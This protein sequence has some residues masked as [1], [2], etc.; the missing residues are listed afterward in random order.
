MPSNEQK[1]IQ[2]FSDALDLDKSIIEDKLEYNTIP[3][4]DSI[5]HMTLIAAIDDSFDIML[6]T[7]DIIDMS[8]FAKAKKIISKHGIEF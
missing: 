8:T 1:L 7:D 6:E 2:I 5:G 4:W 3:E